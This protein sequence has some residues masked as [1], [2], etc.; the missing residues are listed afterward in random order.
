MKLFGHPVHVML[1][2]F[3]SALFPMECVCYG[4]A[5]FTGNSTFAFAAF[6]AIMGGVALG[7]FSAIFGAWDMINIT[8]ENTNARGAALVH[9]GVNVSVVLIYSVLAFL[10]Y[11]KYPELPQATLVLLLVRAGTNVLMLLGNY[12]G[13]NLL[14]KY[15][16]GIE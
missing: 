13:G 1:I 3:P 4:I 14:F 7:W 11:P 6:F 9:G 10:L 5:Y 12:L 8:P 16:V 15:K 2:H